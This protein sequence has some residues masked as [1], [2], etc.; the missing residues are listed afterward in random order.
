MAQWRFFVAILYSIVFIGI[1]ILIYSFGISNG[2]FHFDDYP[3]LSALGDFGKI[4]SLDDFFSYLFSGIAGPTGRPLSLLSFLIDAQTWPT[5][6]KPFLRTNAILHAINAT[7]LALACWLLLKPAQDTRFAGQALT[8]ATL[9]ALLWLLHPYWV[10]TVLYAVQRMAILS[11]TFCLLG[12]VLYLQGRLLTISDS[13]VKQRKGW[14]IT[15]IGIGAGTVLGVFSKENAAVLPLLI[16]VVEFAAVRQLWKLRPSSWTERSLLLTLLVLP[17]LA[18]LLYLTHHIDVESFFVQGHTR[19]FSMYERLITQPGILLEYLGDLL[20]PKPGYAGLFQENYPFAHGLLSPPITIFQ[21]L[22]VLGLIFAAFFWRRHQP[23]LAL[24]ILF[25]FAGHIIESSILMLEL[26]FEH[27]S[28]LPSIFLFL[29]IITAL[30]VRLHLIGLFAGVSLA[31][32]FASMT[33]SH[34]SLWGR[35]LELSYYWAHKNPDSYRAQVVAAGALAKAQHLPLALS[36]LEDALN[37]HPDSP[38]LQLSYMS[39]LNSAGRHEESDLQVKHAIA[40]IKNGPLDIHAPDIIEPLADAYADNK[41]WALSRASNLAVIDAF[42]QREAYADRLDLQSY[43]YARGLIEL[44]DGNME[45][46]CRAFGQ[47]Q[48]LTGNIG[49]DLLIFALMASHERYADARYFL[50]SAK[51]KIPLGAQAKLRFPPTW[52]EDEIARLEQTLNEDQARA[53]VTSAA[54]CRNL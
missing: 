31:F 13:P 40:A 24:A 30:V 49:T 41:P 9:T 46:S 38:A 48:A 10:S 39:Y 11:A 53:G 23:L 19:P 54:V 4:N 1:G 44:H 45:D 42:Q 12:L 26:K 16:L 17:S 52:Y 5:D 8:I 7:L 25:F 32:I 51:A 6:P 18:L 27:R 2:A 37:R 47:M 29:P 34:A 50:E 36:L 28:Y 35:P 33:F 3:N 20:I 14:W 43:A 15:A 22:I 21:I